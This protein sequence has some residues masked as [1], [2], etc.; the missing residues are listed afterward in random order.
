M[1]LTMCC[2]TLFGLEGI[3]A[4]ELRFGGKLTDV[5]AEN[6]R[7][8]F[9]GDE[10]TLAWANLNLRCAERV[11]IRLGAFKA[12]TFDQ[13][14]EGVK[15]LPW[16]EFIPAD[17]AFPVKGHSLD[18]A[19]HSIPDCQKIVKK[20][21]VSRLSQKYGQGWFEESGAKYQIQFAIMHDTAEIYLDTS[22]AGLHKRGY[23][24]NSNA[25]P[26]RE[27]L[28]AA[29]V[30]L[31]RWRGREPLLDPFCGSGTIAIE[32]AM[33]AQRRAPG[34]LRRFDAEKWTC[35]DKAVWQQAREDA[36]CMADATKRDY[37]GS[38]ILFANPPY[39]ERLL[40]QKQAEQLYTALGRA[41][42]NSPMKQYILSSDPLF[43]R[44]YGRPADKRRKLY[45]GMIKC[46][47][48]MYF[49]NA[50][51]MPRKKV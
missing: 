4:D 51:R 35:F 25:A 20:A 30:K 5:R 13:L 33:I 24:A 41:T 22:G 11:L 50:P 14:F 18:S 36:L 9:E 15:A 44:C 38:G 1:E 10:N 8:F 31:A 23:R 32:A 48:H 12:K 17:G 46:E 27:T 26:L 34:L 45:N 42:K 39:G 16:E 40:D 3:V 29:M 7:V 28:A 19:L 2:P 49:K 47:L 37:S 43:E 21:V 6:G